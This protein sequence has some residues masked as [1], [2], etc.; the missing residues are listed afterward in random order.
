MIERRR[1]GR[2]AIASAALAASLLL[3]SHGVLRVRAQVPPP[4]AS[5]VADA[6]LDGSST[7]TDTT[8]GAA[9][10]ITVRDGRIYAYGDVYSANPRVG[11]I[12]EYGLDLKPTGR[13]VWLRQAN[14]PLITH[15]TGLTWDDRWGTFLGDTFKK[16]ALIYRLD[17]KRAWDDGNLD[18]AVLD[19]ID[20]DA[21]VNGC[22][23]TFVSAGGRTLIATADYGDIRP[24]IRLYDPEMLLKARRSSAP[25]VV[26]HRALCG[27][28]NQNLYWDASTGRLTCV[29]NVIEGRGWR[30]DII[31]LS[32]A[33]A[34]G[35]AD[36]AGARI[37][38]FTFSQH[39]ELEGYWPLD[40]ERS[41]FVTSRRDGNLV[42]GRIQATEPRLSQPGA[43]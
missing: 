12:R 3:W 29:Q 41:L 18:G 1:S 11:V 25:G 22:R 2:S 21:A 38:T 20:D 19:T 37:K 9:Q 43:P 17:W 40:N 24:E 8:L 13:Q 26:V 28:F 39:D 5:W 10:G 23:P 34:Q 30:L 16:N 27:P 15:P 7:A 4:D 32:K 14:R 33:I 42:L 31:D 35:R 36:L 6:V